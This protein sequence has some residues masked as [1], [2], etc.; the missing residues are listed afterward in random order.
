M[1][2]SIKYI[3]NYNYIM[4]CYLIFFFILFIIIVFFY[5]KY[6]SR[7][8]FLNHLPFNKCFIINISNTKEGKR[9]WNLIQTHNILKNINFIKFEAIN[10][11]KYKYFNELRQGIVSLKWDQGIWLNGK[12]KMVHM[13]PG[14]IG[15][16]LSHFNIWKE[17]SKNKIP[18]TLIL[19]DDAIVIQKKFISIIKSLMNKLPSN[20]DILLL[21]FYLNRGNFDKKVT[22]DIYRVKDFVLCHSYLVSLDGA[23]KLLKLGIIDKPLD[24]WLS[25]KSKLVNIYRHNL[26]NNNKNNPS[27]ILIKQKRYK[28]QIKNTNDWI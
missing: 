4:F 9:R 5:N 23:N 25:S 6:L 27:S 14:E 26:V 12:S 8:Y 3:L 13:D 10:G 2:T 7:E 28:K 24:T 21:G 19:E 15:C 1:E 17:I 18:I 11:R 20:W 16:I 22:K